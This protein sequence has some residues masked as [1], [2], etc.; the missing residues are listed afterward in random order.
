LKIFNLPRRKI[1]RGRAM[2]VLI[3]L[4]GAAAAVIS[5]S[6]AAP[7]R[8]GLP[9]A[10]GAAPVTDRGQP[11]TGSLRLT[12]G[13]GKPIPARLRPVMGFDN[14]Y[15]NYCGTTERDVLAE[16]RELVR[17][18]LAAAGYRTVIL[19]DCWMAAKRT[20]SGQLTWNRKTFPTGIPR[21]A[22]K[23]H[24]MG[25][26]FGLYEDAGLRTCTEMP[27]DLGHYS[28][29]VQTFKS[30]HVN[31][32]KIDMCQFPAG[33]TFDQ[34]SADFAQFGQD[35]AAAGIAYEEEL[36]VKALINYGDTSPEYL[37][38]VETSSAVATMWRVTPDERSSGRIAVYEQV[39]ELVPPEIGLEQ[40]HINLVGTFANM[41]IRGFAVDLPLAAYARPGHWNDLD[42]LMT[43]NAN[44]HFT[45]S[46]AVTQLS[47]W[48]ELA[49]PLILSTDVG[50]LSPTLLADLKNRAMIAIDQS[51]SQGQE[52]ASQGSVVAVE[53][54][55]PRG[56]TALLL[57]NMSSQPAG[58]DVALSR[59][60]FHV[61]SLSVTN[62]WSGARWT[63][64]GRFR[65]ELGAESACLLQ[66]R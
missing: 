37:Q 59:L 17:T 50:T 4:A 64:T 46:E 58:F 55:D 16:A 33:S 25:L 56:G 43:G 65:F 3:T 34:I 51:G 57:V 19:D 14:W 44:Y 10:S 26:K 47:I 18:G 1:K 38:A 60:G 21:L 61:P 62:I 2:A 30:W 8:A 40:S 24:A 45:K 20:A 29:D 39:R 12:G 48:A 5:L 52:V 53:K 28:T 23:I 11:A 27:G 6:S 22:A 35:L 63:V 49:S 9:V 36:P 41:V 42:V 32:V 54:P 66:V 7:E 13:Y 15:V 31:L